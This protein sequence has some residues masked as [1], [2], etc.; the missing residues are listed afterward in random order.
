MHSFIDAKAICNRTHNPK[1]PY[2]MVRTLNRLVH[3]R[4]STT[5]RNPMTLIQTSILF[6]VHL[7]A[8]ANRSARQYLVHTKRTRGNFANIRPGSC[9][10]AF[11]AQCITIVGCEMH[12]TLH[13]V[14]HRTNLQNYRAFTIDI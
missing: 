5:H 8:H 13:V 12:V 10:Y 1:T 2:N 14:A 3:Q 7:C 6:S 11:Y 9:V 4:R